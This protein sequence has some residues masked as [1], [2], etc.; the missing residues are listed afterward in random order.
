MVVNIFSITS[1]SLY[2]H[3]SITLL[4][5]HLRACISVS[6]WVVVFWLHLVVISVTCLYKMIYIYT[7]IEKS[8]YF[9]SLTPGCQGAETRVSGGVTPGCREVLVIMRRCFSAMPRHFRW[10]FCCATT[11]GEG[12]FL[13]PCCNQQIYFMC[14]VIWATWKSRL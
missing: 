6:K 10:V 8:T 13:L 9:L 11:V 7:F 1:L 3:S 12:L 4:F 5:S 2:Y 14:D